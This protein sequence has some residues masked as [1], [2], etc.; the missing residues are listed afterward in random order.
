MKIAETL[1]AIHRDPHPSRPVV[2]DDYNLIQTI[3]LTSKVALQTSEVLLNH[4]IFSKIL[5]GFI[6]FPCVL[7]SHP[8]KTLRI[9]KNN[10]QLLSAM[11]S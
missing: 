7:T 2:P 8:L 4:K 3:K 10:K 6:H 5:Y 9:M 1:T 11:K